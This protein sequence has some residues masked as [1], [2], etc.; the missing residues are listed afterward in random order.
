MFLG[1]RTTAEPLGELEKAAKPEE[2]TFHSKSSSDMLPAWRCF[3]AHSGAEACAG[4]LAVPCRHF[5]HEQQVRAH[6]ACWGKGGLGG[7]ST[8]AVLI[9]RQGGRN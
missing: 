5:V 6:V 4:P 8:G 3:A 2:G 9:E 7:A 1:W